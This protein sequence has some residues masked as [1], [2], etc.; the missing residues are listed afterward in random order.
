[1]VHGGRRVSGLAHR[2]VWVGTKYTTGP[3]TRSPLWRAQVEFADDL[4]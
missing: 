1:V 4:G 2:S 3:H